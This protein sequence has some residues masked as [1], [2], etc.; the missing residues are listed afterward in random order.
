MRSSRLVASLSALVLAGMLVTPVSAA[1]STFYVDGKLGSDSNGGTSLG[2]AFKTIAKAAMSVPAGSAGAGSTIIVKGYTD[3]VYRERPIPTGWGRT[4]TSTAP[5]VFQALSYAASSTAYVKPIVSGADPA[6]ATGNHWTAASTAGVWYTPW[7]TAPFD[8]GKNSASS[9]PTSIFQDTNTWLWEQASL[10]ALG[11]RASKGK[12]GY[13]YDAANDR[14]YVSAVSSSGTTA[15][16]DPTAHQV[17][18]PMRSAFLLDGR[19]GADYIQIRGFEVRHSANGIA[20]LYGADNGT[21][22]DN[23]LTG[24]IYMGISVSG[25]QTTSGPDPADG[26]TIWRNRGSWNTIELIKLTS[27]VT[28]AS[29]CYNDASFNGLAGILVEGPP[30]GSS[31]TGKTTGVTLCFNKLHDHEFNPTGQAY[32]N[33]A[34]ALIQNGALSVTVRD[35][36]LWNNDVGLHITQGATNM[37]AMNGLTITRNLI[38]GNNRFG[39]YFLDGY[40]G[41]GLGTATA[42][43]DLIWGNGVGVMVDRGSKNKTLSHE[44][45]YANTGDGIH[46]GGSAPVASASVAITRSLV[47]G[48]GGYGLW[49]V[50]GNGNTASLSYTGFSGNVKGN[51][52]GSP[53]KTAVNTQAPGYMSTLPSSASYLKIGGSSYQYTAGPGSTPIGAKY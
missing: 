52:T 30:S 17:D 6:P 42:S 16:T 38:W 43:Y 31:Y 34:G 20:Y 4:G 28:N 35:N 49:L 5:I 45:V 27:G 15:G 29:V 14:L 44:T 3:Y 13:W 50:S 46:V 26:M 12:G 19:S 1:A 25:Y 37:P 22:A 32:N 53:S 39:L 33:A 48:N 9:L 2:S 23:V 18:V 51:I 24:N 47:T 8:F 21:V 10:S 7:S 41:S 11:T 40:R 36:S